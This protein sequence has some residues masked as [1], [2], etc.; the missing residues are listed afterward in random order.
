MTA[1]EPLERRDLLSVV[2]GIFGGRLEVFDARSGFDDTNLESNTVTLSM[3]D[4]QGAPHIRVFDPRG[5]EDNGTGTQNVANAFDYAVADLSGTTKRVYVDLQEGDDDLI[6]NGPLIVVG[7]PT[8]RI[9]VFG[10]GPSAT[11]VLRLFGNPQVQEDVRIVRDQ[12]EGGGPS[13][14][15]EQD[16]DGF[17]GRIAV[18]GMEIIEF[19]G[20]VRNPLALDTLTVR[21]DQG[22]SQ[23]RV[24]NSSRSD[25]DP[26]RAWDEVISSVLPRIQ[27][28]GLGVFRLDGSFEPV[29]ATFVT[30]ELE[31]AAR[32]E[33]ISDVRSQD[34][35]I[36]EGT[37]GQNDDYTVRSLGPSQLAVTDN[38]SVLQGPVT[39]NALGIFNGENGDRLQINTRGGD[40]LV[41]VDLSQT[42][43]I[44]APITYDG[45]LGSDRLVVQGTP[46]VAV[47]SLTYTPGPDWTKG[48]LLYAAVQDQMLIDFVGLEP[49]IDLVVAATAIV[50]ATNADNAINYSQGSVATRGLVSVD[51]LETYEFANKTNLVIN[52]G[53]GSDTVNLNNPTT[54]TGLTGNITVNGGDPTASDTIIVNG[55]IG[56]DTIQYTPSGADSGTVTV[57][58]LPPVAFSGKEHLIIN[59]LGGGDT[60]TVDSISIDGLMVLTP[61]SSFDS[62]LLEFFAD[63]TSNVGAP[64]LQYKGL[65]TGGKLSLLD[66]GQV[67]DDLIYRGT[68]LSD[69]F[70]VS[71]I[72]ATTNNVVLS[73]RASAT[74][75]GNDHLPVNIAQIQKLTLAGLAG[76]D[77]FNVPGNLSNVP[78]LLSRIIIDG[79]DPS[80][81]DVLNLTAAATDVTVTLGDAT[82]APPATNNTVVTG[83]GIPVELIGVEVAN[84]N[85]NDKK[86]TVVG[87]SL[88][89]EI[90]YTPTGVAAGTFT[91]AGLNTVFNFVNAVD[92]F[93]ITG[94][95]ASTADTV[96]VRGTSG[97]DFIAVDS[98]NR[99]VT[100][101][102]PSGTVLKTVNLD[103]TI[104]IVT[105]QAGAGNDT[106]L[107]TPAPATATGQG[108]A[109]V[110]VLV[111]IN[112]LINVDGG[113]PGASDALVV[114]QADGS[115][116][117]ASDF[118]VINRSRTPDEGVVRVFRDGIAMPDIAYSGVEIVSPILPAVVN[119]VQD[120]NLLILGPDNY[121]QNEFLSTAAYL[122][123][124]STINVDNLAIFPNVFEHRFVT[125]DQD[126]FRVVAQQTGTIDFQVY[127]RQFLANGA[128]SIPGG[129]NLEIEAYDVDGT[130][131]DNVAPTFG[132]ND[133]DADERIRI[134]VVAGQAYYL[135][136]FGALRIVPEG[137]PLPSDVVNGYNLTVLN[138][139]PPVPWGLEV[140]DVIV[141][142]TTAGAATSVSFSSA[143]ATLST[144]NDTYNGKFVDFTSGNANGLRGKIVDYV[145]ATKTFTLEAPLREV[146][147]GPVVVPAAGSNFQIES[148]DTG[149]SQLDNVTRDDTPT[150]FLRLDDGIFLHDL[151]G[152]DTD[153]TPP[154]QVIR[155]PFR[156]QA[157]LA[158]YRIAI[159]D[160]GSTP[161]Q[162]G[163]PPQTPVGFATATA[164]EGVY[165]FTFTTPLSSGS[166]FITARV[167]MI[168]PATP[169]QTGFGGR[170]LPLEIV[171]DV[172]PPPV[173]FGLPFLANDGLDPSS[174]SGD[175]TDNVTND[176]T[177]SLF[178]TAEANSIV[179]VYADLNN[180][181]VTEPTDLLLG[182][183][184]AIP[185]SGTN[186]YPG[187]RWTLT[188][189]VSLNDPAF[190]PT[191]DGVRRLLVMA[192][193]VAGNQSSAEGEQL[194]IFLDTV[195]PQVTDVF[196]TGREDYDLFGLKQPPG[197]EQPPHGPTP[198]VNSIT[199]RLQDLPDRIAGFLFDAIVEGSAEARG[200]ISVRGDATGIVAIANVQATNDAVNPGDPATAFIVVT[201]AQPLPDD[202][203]TLTIL[204]QVVDLA[205]NHLDG[206]SNASEP[207]LGG[208][209]F[210]SGNAVPGGN[211]VARFTVDSRPEIGF[212]AGKS[213]I[214]DING[215]GF[216]DPANVDAT[217]RDLAFQFGL[218]SDQRF[219]GK[220]APNL[221]GADGRRFDVL[222]A[223]GRVDSSSP[224]RFLI[225]TDGNGTFDASIDSP[226]QVSALAVAG[227]FDGNL[228][229]GDEAALFTG[230]TWYI[231]T[232]GFA[233]ATSFATTIQG[234]PMAGDFN[235]DIVEDLATYR[236]D[237]FFFD[238]GANGGSD[239]TI[240][241]GAPGVSERPVAAD[242]DGDGID[243][244]GLWIPHTGTEQ[245]TT[246]WR[247]LISSNPAGLNHAFSPTP[248]GHDLAY[249]FGDP[250][251]LP[252]V[253]NFDPP[254][255]PASAQTSNSS[256]SSGNTSSSSSSS[257][258]S[259]GNSSSQSS[260]ANTG[261]NSAADSQAYVASLYHDILGRAAD[262]SGLNYFVAQ[263][264]A[265]TTR[266]SVAS[267]LLNSREHLGNVV[268]TF[269][270]TYLH[271]A[272]DPGGRAYWVQS[273]VSGATEDSVAASFLLSAEYS[274]LH[275]TNQGF[276]EALYADLLGR[277]ADTGGL[278]AHASA[279]ASGK[280]RAD[281]VATFLSSNERYR[282][283]VDE[284]YGQMLGRHADS[285]GLQWFSEKLK[286][287]QQSARSLA[288]TLLASDEYFGNI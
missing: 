99:N 232:N 10:G 241:F 186:Q 59:G 146:P 239:L 111:P 129:G 151:P 229:N 222:A 189:N 51:D 1:F 56:A 90:T 109:P 130:R 148:T 44:D 193:D 116:L 288:R 158:G 42:D 18:S 194:N 131:I 69:T 33:F 153:D 114:A 177:P 182:Q 156:D 259:T 262:T 31:G 75:P 271:R 49:V 184:V 235:G 286:S 12:G 140:D 203:F 211:F 103:A 219:A 213:V 145:G 137:G 20:G 122:G 161:P 220:F 279:L 7:G 11:D 40:D 3:V 98:P 181:G 251:A 225:D 250:T 284:L 35:L 94:G 74:A 124:G 274:S 100:V 179:R 123:S 157:L 192:E 244:V 227:N 167:Q 197:G 196:I 255:A 38:S 91:N 63:I 263:L 200:V 25:G 215:N 265:G 217:N 142:A 21:M 45:G 248:L 76:D 212:Y 270:G 93:S 273:L 230:S 29:E 64:S 272:A 169:K 120:P 106:V 206:E 4:I 183:T 180:N 223:Y 178:G 258:S 233:L 39:I 173:F 214:V 252:I 246:E 208:P 5:V 66:T 240:A 221:Q 9:D 24:Q 231:L 50:N 107:V 85:T 185:L 136:V 6:V 70:T 147:G 278:T 164:E 78:P 204:D 160:E 112:L 125:P 165:T 187:G 234:Y 209:Y 57:N 67:F 224:Y 282:R 132:T 205:G 283:V 149:V 287:G 139:G 72:D 155:I 81:S 46:T 127:F 37:D 121:E 80:A 117:P 188:S 174:N 65:G 260:A 172:T 133:T 36:I 55:T 228:L 89:D 264:N 101:N 152:N 285:S 190:F 15:D 34:T 73:T 88:D 87:T 170:S 102:N 62:G 166:H 253:G 141:L 280:N 163:T 27:F 86:L 268:D 218:P 266:D 82:L 26:D 113:S 199:I 226:V 28:A 159:F 269:Y 243:D 202:R 134:P 168:D 143:S 41:T 19:F 257:S 254:V 97:P 154:D 8:I 207:Q 68:D 198:L 104:E 60:L 61:G 115:A 16:I 77:L 52:A 96:V 237:T 95:T 277:G 191:K 92:T 119:P 162:V 128:G 105:V 275:A 261:T 126:W 144:V 14:S 13:Q 176:T 48:R 135:H 23:A 17:G 118:V 210:P 47:S 43:L 53:A 238:F 108:G 267:V 175:L 138:E 110:G 256:Q 30:N 84:L 171:V 32:Y 242:M 236:N 201:F 58:A 249:H 71:N 216:Y 83:Y 195:G 2:A 245:G 54:P 150:I 281:L 276:I 79:G 22:P 247:F